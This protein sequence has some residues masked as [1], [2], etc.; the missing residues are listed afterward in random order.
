MLRWI[1]L[2]ALALTI[3]CCA[4]STLAQ[5]GPTG[6]GSLER[7]P[8]TPRDY[9][10]QIDN[11]WKR[12]QATARYVLPPLESAVY[13]QTIEDFHAGHA[14]VVEDIRATWG[15]YLSGTG[16]YFVALQISR[17]AGGDF[18][19]GSNATLFGE[20]VDAAGK[21]VVG[22]QATRPLASSNG[23]VY[24]DLSLKLSPGSYTATVGLATGGTP[25][26][27]VSTQI[28]AD[29]IDPKAFGVTKLLLSD[30]I[31]PLSIPQKADDPFAFGGLKVVSRGDLGFSRSRDLWLFLVVRNPGLDDSSAPAIRAR[32]VLKGPEGAESRRRILPVSD[33]TPTPLQGFDKHWGLGIP[34]DTSKLAVGDYAVSLELTD[35][36]L[37]RTWNAGERFTIVAP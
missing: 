20:V 32:V 8:K 14:D 7:D 16:E 26:S 21:Q 3:A 5:R 11:F 17:A 35:T 29:P 23:I 9:E 34:L 36:I 4:T 18:V 28:A 19:E 1:R 24:T 37:N 12:D 30:D 13:K 6:G 31:H 2:G 25:R 22:F 10:R 33:L 15:E 27:M